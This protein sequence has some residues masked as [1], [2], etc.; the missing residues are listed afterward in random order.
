MMS[1]LLV[2]ILRMG[3]EKSSTY[4]REKMSSAF[5]KMMSPSRVMPNPILIM[6]FILIIVGLIYFGWWLRGKSLDR[7]YS[8][9]SCDCC[10][11]KSKQSN[12]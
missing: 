10:S 3:V 9:C 1:S 6:I 5:P 8:I 11:G 4:G 7:N 2:S 12:K